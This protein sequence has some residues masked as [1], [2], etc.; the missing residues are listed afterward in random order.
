MK[1]TH[2]KPYFKTTH[3]IAMLALATGFT[4]AVNVGAQAAAGTN[5][6]DPAA[7]SQ[8]LQRMDQLEQKAK[9][10]DALEA[11]V[12]NLKSGAAAPAVETATV[13][14]A[15]PKIDFHVLGDFTYHV[16][17]NKSDKNTFGE[18]D[19]DPVITAKLSEDA[20]VL[21]DFVIAANHEGF[22]F[23]VERFLLQ[24]N[25]NDY[26]HI[27]AGRFHTA[28]GFYNNFY[29]NGTYFQTATERPFIF[30]FE[31]GD[32][33]ILPVHTTGVSINGDIPSGPLRLHYVAEVG[34]GRSYDPGMNVFQVEDNND[35]KAVNLAISA[36][37]E[38]MPGWKLGA[39]VYHDNLTPAPAPRTDQ[40]ILSAYAVYMTP[41]IEW[42]NEI[43]SMRNAVSGM[44]TH[45]TTAAYTQFSKK[46]GKIRPYVRLEW[47]NASESDPV[48]G[49]I[50]ENYNAWGP[51]VGI[52]YDFTPMMALKAEY[53]YTH[54]PDEAGLNEF[55]L[56]WTFRY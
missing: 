44:G 32:G 26:L 36:R 43:V 28:I 14:D 37:P 38:F 41:T 20:G 39:S 55:T 19:I 49:Q 48:L 31:D 54:V 18:G 29:H 1:A 15:F 22:S 23:E 2:K 40:F 33:G 42:L 50:G 56:Q 6:M 30:H 46:F 34:N 27:E 4:P 25:V 9:R 12:S 24:Y 45:W 17:D 21:G 7:M 8:L 47:R 13:R 35:F 11:E 52:R 51:T 53:Q 5:Y 3:K 16:S 10:V